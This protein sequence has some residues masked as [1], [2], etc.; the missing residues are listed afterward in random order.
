[1]LK[2]AEV[3]EIQKFFDTGYSILDMIFIKDPE[4]SNEHRKQEIS[5]Y[6][7]RNAAHKK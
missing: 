5:S 1:M 7:E 6:K 3:L 4:S 2:E